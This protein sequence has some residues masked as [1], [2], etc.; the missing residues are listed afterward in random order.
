MWNDGAHRH[1]GHAAG[2]DSAAWR[3][4]DAEALHAEQGLWASVHGS[5]VGAATRPCNIGRPIGIVEAEMSVATNT[6]RKGPGCAC[7]DGR[8]DARKQADK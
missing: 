3:N 1:P 5:E 7:A 6:G 4:G 2:R 8:E